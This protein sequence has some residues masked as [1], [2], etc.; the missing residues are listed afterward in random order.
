[1]QVVGFGIETL[2]LT[3]LVNLLRQSY[4]LLRNMVIRDLL[5]QIFSR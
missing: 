4:T 5:T 1:M 2:F 3:K